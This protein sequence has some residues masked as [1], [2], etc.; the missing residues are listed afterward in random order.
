MKMSSF[1][2]PINTIYQTKKFPFIN[3]AFINVFISTINN[4]IEVIDGCDL[5]RF[6]GKGKTG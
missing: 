3:T 4:S 1:R 2:D 5:R 6:N